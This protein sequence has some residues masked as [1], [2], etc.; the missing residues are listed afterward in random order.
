[1]NLS[2]VEKIVNVFKFTFSS[3]LQIELFILCLLLF[4]FL[5]INL[6]MK[7]KIVNYFIF[8]SFFC[9]MFLLCL[10]N[11]DYVVYCID[12]VL[13]LI[14]G[15]IYFPSPVIYFFIIL[16]AINLLMFTA[17][18]NKLTVFKKIIN[19]VCFIILIL[20]FFSFV[21]LLVYNNIDL[22]TVTD[23][24]KNDTIL[25]V[26]QV[27]NLVFVGWILYTSF[28]WLYHYYKKKFDKKKD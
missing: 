20:L 24:Y 12:K 11:W 26:V 18:T 6:R 2:F 1:M 19:Y 22:K 16:F 14:I 17:F 25:S 27:G 23:L 21:S 28:Y 8:F 13:S 7:N 9:F 10:F 15:Y 4:L 5:L 3:Y